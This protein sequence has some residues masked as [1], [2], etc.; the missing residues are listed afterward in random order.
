MQVLR[1]FAHV[2]PHSAMPS[3]ACN[4]F[5]HI[6]CSCSGTWLSGVTGQMMCNCMMVCMLCSAS[7]SAAN[8]APNRAGQV[9][10]EQFDDYIS[11]LYSAVNV[12]NYL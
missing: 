9:L 5:V 6:C 2:T 1:N 12:T 11:P 10:T 4:Q 7:D 8:L 3:Y